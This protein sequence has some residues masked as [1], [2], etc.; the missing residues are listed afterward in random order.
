MSNIKLTESEKQ[1]FKA[2]LQ[3]ASNKF[4]L[5]REYQGKQKGEYIK[6]GALMMLRL[7]QKEIKER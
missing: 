4:A 6:G 2:V 5:A 3:D 7:I 1:K